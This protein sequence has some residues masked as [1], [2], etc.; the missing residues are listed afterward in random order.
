MR[1]EALSLKYAML[2]T[3]ANTYRNTDADAYTNKDTNTDT[4]IDTNKLLTSHGDEGRG[5]K[6][7]ICYA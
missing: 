5:C 2:E 4:N 6:P 3:N 1:E 7:Q